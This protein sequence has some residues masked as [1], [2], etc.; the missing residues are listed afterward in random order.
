VIPTVV[1]PVLIYL[2]EHSYDTM[3][4]NLDDDPNYASDF[5]MLQYLTGVDFLIDLM[6]HRSF[7]AKHWKLNFIKVAL[8]V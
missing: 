3:N 7:L 6:T 4:F 1:L 8:C 5:P 2:I